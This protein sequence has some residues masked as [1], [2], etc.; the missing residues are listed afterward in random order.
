MSAEQY[1][2]RLLDEVQQESLDTFLAELRHTISPQRKSALGLQPLDEFLEAVLNPPSGEE[3][4]PPASRQTAWQLERPGPD[5][6][7]E[8]VGTA[9][10]ADV[11]TPRDDR[12]QRHASR[13]IKPKPATIEISSLKSAAGKTSLLYYLCAVATLPKAVGGKA[14]TVVYIDS[15]GRFS[16]TRLM[17]IMQHHMVT[18]RT[19]RQDTNDGTTGTT[20]IEGTTT[21]DAQVSEGAITTAKDND[22]DRDIALEALQHIHVFRPQSS[23]QVMS[24][25]NSLPDYLLDGSRH[26]S[27]YRRLGLVVVD[28]ATAFYWQDRFDRDMWR[29]DAAA[30]GGPASQPS[31]VPTT[32]QIIDGLK[33]VQDRFE[34]VVVFSSNRSS[35]SSGSRAPHLSTSAQQANRGRGP[36]HPKPYQDQNQGQTQPQPQNQTDT[37]MQSTP[38]AP[39]SSVWTVSPW[40]AYASLTL[41]LS[42]TQVVQFAPHMTLDECLRDADKRFE[43]VGNARFVAKVDD[44]PGRVG[45]VRTELNPGRTGG[46]AFT[47]RIAEEGVTVE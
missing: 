31:P 32:A 1:G 45:G 46:S 10:Y 3:Q 11:E 39:D 20:D 41:D 42:R 22:A 28:S 2:A 34:C 24:V 12:T 47:F 43:A 17:Q 35:L 23:S 37:E 13:Q 21:T 8:D 25:L 4:A 16:A 26:S 38:L 5:D 7:N 19:Q 40:T 36:Q 18:T 33:A 6:G 44:G 30:G 27:I 9:G 29:L 14:S 15:D